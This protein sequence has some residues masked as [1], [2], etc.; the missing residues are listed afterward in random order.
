MDK[1]YEMCPHC[2]DEVEL[3]EYFDVQI[4][5]SCGRPILPCSMCYTCIG[6]NTG[7]QLREKQMQVE[8]ELGFE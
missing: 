2:N 6:W 4:C 5:P 1:I 3:E 7:C 8:R